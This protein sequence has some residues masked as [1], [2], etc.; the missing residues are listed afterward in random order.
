MKQNTI[1]HDTNAERKVINVSVKRHLPKQ[2]NEIIPIP[3]A[4]VERKVI[5]ISVKRQLTIPLKFFNALGFTNEAECFLQEDGL[6]IRPLRTA[7]SSEHSE[8]ILAELISQGYE[9]QQLLDK[10]KELSMA[11]H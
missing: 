6:L 2:Q 1:N 9:G 11:T 10:F 3:N 8:K 5:C 7:D 4:D